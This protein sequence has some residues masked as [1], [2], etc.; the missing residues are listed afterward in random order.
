MSSFSTY[1]FATPSVWEGVGRLVDFGDTLTEY[2]T[3]PTPEAAD[4]IAFY[5]DW[6]AIGEDFQAAM[7]AAADQGIAS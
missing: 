3:S 1:L 4:T 5:L 2:N 6:F 7:S